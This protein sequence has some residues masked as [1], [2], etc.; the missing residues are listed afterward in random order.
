MKSLDVLPR[1]P[2]RRTL[3]AAAMAGVAALAAGCA[4][5]NT[6]SVDVSSYGTWPDGRKPGTYAIER[7]PSQQANAVEQDR[8]EAAARPALE[9]AGFRQAAA[10]QAEY[11]VQL[12]ARATESYSRDPWGSSFYWRSDYWYYGGSP[13]RGWYGP[14]WGWAPTFNDFPDVIREAG[15]L[16]RDR[17]TNAVIYETR[18]RYT[19]RSSSGELL[20][21]MFDAAMKDFPGPAISPRTVTL[22]MPS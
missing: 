9:A 22:T 13:R 3:L 16:I 6:L 18:A 11:V 2:G 12:G 4:G 8:V 15:V 10:D 20:P 19:S 14:G 5:L 21:L 17:K 1:A 7:L